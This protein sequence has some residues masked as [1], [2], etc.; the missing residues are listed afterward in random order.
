MEKPENT[1][2]ITDIFSRIAAKVPASEWARLPTDL[3]K[4]LDHYLYGTKMLTE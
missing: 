3:S 2:S 4:N 1:E